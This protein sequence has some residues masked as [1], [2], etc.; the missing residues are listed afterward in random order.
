MTKTFY[1]AQI[2]FYSQSIKTYDDFKL[3]L[4]DYR[5]NTQLEN[6][7]IIH[8]YPNITKIEVS[9]LIYSKSIEKAQKTLNLITDSIKYYAGLNGYILEKKL[10][11]PFYLK[12]WKDPFTGEIKYYVK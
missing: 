9:L 4:K 12:F 3:I 7:S 2:V 11:M 1:N 6:I 8:G 5:R 10:S